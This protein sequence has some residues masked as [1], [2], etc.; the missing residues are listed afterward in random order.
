MTRTPTPPWLPSPLMKAS[1]SRTT[2]PRPTAMTRNR[3]TT[4]CI[5]D[6]TR[7]A[8]SVEPWKCDGLKRTLHLGGLT[9]ALQR[10]GSSA[11]PGS[12]LPF[13][14]PGARTRLGTLGLVFVP[15]PVSLAILG[16]GCCRRADLG[17]EPSA[18]LPR[19]ARGPAVHVRRAYAHHRD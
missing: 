6:S 16:R 2:T 19:R 15:G 7:I 9:T 5:V 18:E 17:A 14:R 1:P 4:G 11:A 10:V 13:S 8:R 3:S 12:R